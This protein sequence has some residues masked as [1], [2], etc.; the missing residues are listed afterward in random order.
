VLIARKNLAQDFGFMLRSI[1]LMKIDRTD[2]CSDRLQAH[3]CRFWRRVSLAAILICIPQVVEAAWTFTDHTTASGI[4]SVH[5]FSELL[6]HDDPRSLAGGM[7][8]GDYDAD[9]WPDIFF[10]GGAEGGNDLFRN[11]GD[12]TFEEV[13]VSARVDLYGVHATG[14]VF[15]DF[16]GDGWLDLFVLLVVADGTE[17]AFALYQNLGNGRFANVTARSGISLDSETLLAATFADIE[18]DG[19]LDFFVSH[20]GSFGLGEPGG[21]LWRNDGDFQ[22]TDITRAAGFDYRDNPEVLALDW[23][24]SP[25]FTD[26]NLDGNPDLL[27]TGEFGT[28]RIFLNEGDGTFLLHEPSLPGPTSGIGSAI[29]DYDNDGYMDFFISGVAS[30]D[31]IAG[32][33]PVG[34]TGNRLYRNQGDGTFS[35][36]TTAAGVRDGGW[37]WSAAFGDLNLDGHLDLYM[38]NGMRSPEETPEWEYFAEDPARLFVANGSGSFTDQAAGLGVADTGIGRG[39]FLVDLDRDGDLDIVNQNSLQATKVYQNNT[40]AGAHFLVLKLIGRVGNRE[41]IGARVQ[42]TAGGITQ[43]RELQSGSSIGS[44]Q[45]AEAH[46]GLGS[47]TVVEELRIIWPDRVESTFTD[48]LADRHLVLRHPGPSLETCSAPGDSNECTLGGK[49]RSPMECLMEMRVSP[50]PPLGRRGGPGYRIDCQAGDP[51]CD[52]NPE[53]QSSCSV[54]VAICLS[55]DDPRNF[56]CGP[57]T[58]DRLRVRTPGAGSQRAL[59]QTTRAFGLALIGE[60]GAGLA[61]VEGSPFVPL[62]PGLCS[63]SERLTVPLRQ[64]PS[65]AYRKSSTRL[66]IQAFATDGR[67]DQDQLLIRCSP[68][69]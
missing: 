65:G 29:G 3:F 28:S 36:V 12:G 64:K 34:S 6:D 67:R 16:N 19:D 17:N 50:T 5:A 39:T 44:G 35:D 53:D 1:L 13:T 9:G 22:F 55:A 45:A 61:I 31:D 68:P 62:Q 33:T 52:A 23:A 32:G 11:R 66:K 60:G 30:P 26:F 25:N 41:A 47:S 18:G 20:F 7:A 40:Q 59:D 4:D 56:V 2:A 69:Y 48:I 43:V 21:M 46:F 27:L 51:A 15:V 63:A 42:V 38:V 24:L 14:P 37:G 49:V 10:V 57:A 8:V 58:I 54:D